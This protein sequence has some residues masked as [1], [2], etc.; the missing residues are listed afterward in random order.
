MKEKEILN[1]AEKQLKIAYPKCVIWRAPS[2]KQF[3][4]DIFGIYD[5]VIAT[6]EG[7]VIFIQCTTVSN[8]SHRRKKFN[9][10]FANSGFIIPNSY[11]WAWNGKIF[12]MEKF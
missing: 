10:F 2:F 1:L 9:E 5:L 11:I 12:V 7:R 4:K 6:P 3:R 8:I